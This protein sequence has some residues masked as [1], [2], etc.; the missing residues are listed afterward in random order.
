MSADRSEIATMD[1]TDPSKILHVRFIA[2]PWDHA[3]NSP[4]K[5]ISDYLAFNHEIL[6]FV[7]NGENPTNI[8]AMKWY[9]NVLHLKSK[10]VFL[11][12]N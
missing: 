3:S 11:E 7:G 12:S 8:H 5:E 10:K 1:V 2:S 4:K 9:L 6:V